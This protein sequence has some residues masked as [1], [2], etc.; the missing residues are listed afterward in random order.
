[1]VS[2]R[3]KSVSFADPPPEGSRLR[4]PS[5][6]F[7]SGVLGSENPTP[8]SAVEQDGGFKF[9]RRRGKSDAQTTPTASGAPGAPA[10]RGRASGKE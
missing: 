7:E 5:A 9:K 6:P 8:S 10:A 4:K 1:M 2:T 3:R